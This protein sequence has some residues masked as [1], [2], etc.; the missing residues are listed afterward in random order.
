M[1]IVLVGLMYPIPRTP[2]WRQ[3]PNDLTAARIPGY[4]DQLI[5]VDPGEK[6]RHSPR[7][8]P[9]YDYFFH[10][11]SSQGSCPF[12]SCRAIAPTPGQ[13]RRTRKV[14]QLYQ[15]IRLIFQIDTV[16]KGKATVT[17]GMPDRRENNRHR[18]RGG[19]RRGKNSG[20]VAGSFHRRAIR[21]R[22]WRG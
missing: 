15:R 1:A 5:F 16:V 11:I 6:T 8:R 13:S 9:A 4:S 22:E 19:R 3:H 12:P 10:N 7:G 18:G 14:M 17:A 20:R 21:G 2:R